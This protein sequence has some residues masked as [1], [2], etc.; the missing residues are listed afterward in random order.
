MSD[1]DKCEHN[2]MRGCC[3]CA[4]CLSQVDTN[5]GI[6]SKILACHKFKASTRFDYAPRDQVGGVV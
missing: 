3:S 5:Q 1:C 6:R 4:R 2:T